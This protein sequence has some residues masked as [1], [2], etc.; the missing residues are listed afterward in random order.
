MGGPTSKSQLDAHQVSCTHVDAVKLE[1]GPHESHRRGIMK[2]V[3][4]RLLRNSPVLSVGPDAP[5]AESAVR[6]DPGAPQGPSM[7]SR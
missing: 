3:M 6:V 2:A 1:P 4:A 5:E 7:R